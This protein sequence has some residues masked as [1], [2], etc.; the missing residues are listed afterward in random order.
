MRAEIPMSD[1]CGRITL[2]VTVTGVRV[3]KAR[4]WLGSRLFRLAAWVIGVG[5]EVKAE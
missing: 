4:L 3:F 5:C 2:N 1:L